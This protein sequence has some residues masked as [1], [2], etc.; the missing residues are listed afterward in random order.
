MNARR[1]TSVKDLLDKLSSYN[2]FNYLLPG[3]LFAVFVDALTNLKVL[4][5]DLVIG[6]FVYYFAGSVVSRV[7]SLLVE[8]VFM[9]LKWVQHASYDAFV[10]ATKADPKIDLLSE[11][12]NMYRTLVALFLTVAAVVAY[13]SLSLKILPFLGAAAPYVGVA[14]LVV[15]YALAYRKQTAYVKQRVEAAQ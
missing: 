14:V 11:Q 7:G 10:K 6:V 12:N 5:K 1:E 15:L 3:V 9:K 4:Q 8:P 2:I 13:D